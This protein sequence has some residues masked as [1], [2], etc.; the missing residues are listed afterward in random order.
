[1]DTPEFLV[2]ALEYAC[3]IR[4]LQDG[5]DPERTERQLRAA[6]AAGDAILEGRVFEGLCVS[7]PNG[8]RIDDALQIYGGLSGIDL[9]CRDCPANASAQQVRGKVAGCYGFVPL[10]EDTSSLHRAIEGGIETAYPRADWS[11]LCVATTPRWYGLWIDSPIKAESLLVRYLVLSATT[12][13]DQRCRA[14]FAELLNALNVAFDAGCRLHV[15]LYPR[16]RVEGPWWRLAPHCPRCKA[17]WK[18]AGG[19]R[20]NTCGFEG[21]PAPDKK[22]RA[23]G[24]RPYFPL[25]RLLGEEQAGTFLVRYQAFRAQQE[26]QDRAQIQPRAEPPDSPPAD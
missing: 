10:L 25:A 19:R 9:A 2:W 12:I 6:R 3:P 4:G 15:Q 1:M 17:I 16:G 14:A 5:S 18:E 21:H 26:W 24:R 22:R 8:F 7:P 13:D 11:S 20:C 23:R